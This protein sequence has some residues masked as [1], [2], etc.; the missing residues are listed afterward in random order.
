MSSL[1]E[2]IRERYEQN[3]QTEGLISD[4]P[5]I[6]EFLLALS[7]RLDRVLEDQEQEAKDESSLGYTVWYS[8]DER[9]DVENVRQWSDEKLARVLRRQTYDPEADHPT[10]PVDLPVAV[11]SEASQRLDP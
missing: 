7:E 4:W 1:T 10:A 2:K 8:G 5:Q 3:R 9:L 11:V 6:Y